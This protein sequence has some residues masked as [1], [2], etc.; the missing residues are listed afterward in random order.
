MTLIAFPKF[1]FPLIGI[2]CFLCSCD[3]QKSES[4]QG[5]S[6]SVSQSVVESVPFKERPPSAETRFVELD[7][8]KSGVDFVNPIDESHELRYLYSSSMSTG[9]VAIADFDGDAKPDILFAGGPVPNKL[10]RQTSRMQFTDVTSQAG[11]GGGDAWAIGC[12]AADID[13]DGDTDLYVCNYLSPNQLFLNKGDGTFIES[14]KEWG[15]DFIDA[16]HTPSFC[17]YDRDGDLDLYILTNRWYRP[18]GFP[19]EKTIE[20]GPDGR[21]RVIEK[22]ERFYDARQTGADQ[23]TGEGHWESVVVGRPDLLCRNNGA[24]KFEVANKAAGITH[25]GHGLSATWWDWNG[26]GWLD[27]WV[28]N[29]F[30]DADCLYVNRGDGTFVNVVDVA[31]GHTSWFSM[32][33]DFG[34]LNADGL[35]DFLIADMAG[36]NHFK[37]KTAMGSMSAFAWFMDNVE[38]AQLMRNGLF[39]NAGNGRFLEGA[40]LSGLDSTDWTWAVRL[41]DFD[42]D[43]LNDAYFQCGMSR[44]FN[45][46]DDEELKKK[47]RKLTQWERYR[48]LPPLREHNRVFRNLGG[49]NFENTSKDWG[50]DYYGMSYGCAVGDLDQDGALD[51]VS[52]RLDGPVA[53]YHNTGAD[54]GN[55]LT[56]SFEGT[57]SNKQGLGVKAKLFT[58]HD[59]ETPQLRTLVTSRG[60]LGSDQAILHFGLG[61]ASTAARLELYWPSGLTQIIKNLDAGRHHHIVEGG[62]ANATPPVIQSELVFEGLPS[63]SRVKHAEKRYDDFA[64]EPLLPN[65]LSQFGPGQAWSDVNGDGVDDFYLGQGK[66]APGRLIILRDRQG[67]LKPMPLPND[68]DFEDMGCLFFDA[69]GDGD[70]DLYIVSGGVE[71]EDDEDS[72]QDR[73]YLND[74]AVKMTLAPKG[75]LPLARHSGSCVSA[76]DFDRDGDLDLFIGGRT[77]P[78]YYPTAAASQLLRNEGSGRFVD[79]T[80]DLAPALSNSRAGIVTSAVWSDIDN[81]GWIDLVLAR[82]WDTVGIFKNTEGE[83]KALPQSAGAETRR[84]WWNGV[85]SADLDGDGDFDLVVTNFGLNTKYHASPEK[86]A[87]L[88]YGDVVNSGRKHLIEAEF[89]GDIVYPIRGKSCSTAAIPSLANKFSTYKGFAAA[90]LQDIYTPERLKAVKKFSVSHLETSIFWND[91][92]GN[93]SPEA[94]SWE[95]Q[96]APSFGVVVQDFDG[97]GQV[98]IVLAQNFFSPQR[99][100]GRMAGGLSLL[101]RGRKEGGRTIFEPVWPNRSGVNVSGD[102]KSLTTPDLDGDGHPD[103]SFGINDSPMIGLKTKKHPGVTIHLKGGAQN[104]QGIGAR[105]VLNQGR[106]AEVC[107]GGSY[108]S[109]SPAVVH[110]GLAEGESVTSLEV[111]WSDGSTSKIEQ[112]AIKD[113][114]IEINKR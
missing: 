113:G 102:S 68:G 67:G 61:E 98:D 54:A 47:D 73:L 23:W 107:A 93:F 99:E 112:P 87:L 31:V 30:Q 57:K 6:E 5:S 8:S 58:N 50:L 25:R 81:D 78:G 51:I 41:C 96:L 14:A 24:G 106:S 94:L 95:A 62:G 76:A 36:S 104:P 110:F 3:S 97:D 89:E 100:T 101:L 19:S 15:L 105:V 17:D 59:D 86:P 80:S 63:L 44:N 12:A 34:D 71:C 28:G 114:M 35:P 72:L 16:S 42:H 45:E 55:S 84:G 92:K 83:L 48:H 74:G 75:A 10:Y 20:Q 90:T 111:L 82:E 7:I 46:N 66:G 60:Y 69:D 64:R 91:G 85:T 77:V 65:K 21:P 13:N 29:D 70:Q 109:Q 56:L 49:M 53:I 33:A 18:E 43:G 9:G 4:N 103:L 38:P 108:L 1:I 40:F 26:D 27:L 11:V 32:G 79:V 39:L 22:F 37:Q 2:S 52:V 88:F